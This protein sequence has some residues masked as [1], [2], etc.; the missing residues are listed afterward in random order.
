V[1]TDDVPPGA[2][3]VARGRQRTIEGWVERRR[4]GSA[5]AEA[6]RRAREQDQGAG[7]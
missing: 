3:A 5:A 4:A 1:I 6:A 7:A 2:M